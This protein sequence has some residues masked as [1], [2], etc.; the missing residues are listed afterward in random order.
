MDMDEKN[1]L[2]VSNAALQVAMG[3]KIRRFRKEKNKTSAQLALQ[4]G[5]TPSYITRLE[6]GKRSPS[7]EVLRRLSDVLETSPDELLG[8]KS[9]SDEPD[10][11]VGFLNSDAVKNFPYDVFGLKQQDFISLLTSD[12]EYGN[13]LSKTIRHVASLHHVQ[14]GPLLLEVLKFYQQAKNNYFEGIEKAAEAFRQQLGLK[15]G[16]P[17][18]EELLRSTLESR[19]VTIDTFKNQ[20]EFEECRW[21]YVN[22]DKESKLY[23]NE[24]LMPAQRAFC[25][26][27]EIGYM[28]LGEN[29]RRPFDTSELSNF[30]EAY[31]YFKAS[32]FAGS[33]MINKRS[34]DKF[35]LPFLKKKRFNSN[36]F[37]DLKMQTTFES[38]FYRIGELLATH[39]LS[40]YYFL[41]F[42]SDLERELYEGKKEIYSISKA[43]NM[44]SLPDLRGLD[45]REQYCGRFLEINLMRKL[46]EENSDRVICGV[47]RSKG[48]WGDTNYQGDVFVFSIA[49]KTSL[50]PSRLRAVSLSYPINERFK[51]LVGFYDAP[52]VPRK[53]VHVSC[54]RCHLADCK[55]RRSKGQHVYEKKNNMTAIIEF[56]NTKKDA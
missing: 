18:S 21:I 30:A 44:S 45:G 7:L 2:K 1:D 38:Y 23:I 39:G 5:V 31:A 16:D 56:I 14:I 51:E 41:R 13:V 20:D 29:P 28:E 53:E 36:V 33:A 48:L 50:N 40:K 4:I 54:E 15:P 34:F 52:D 19:G 17:L 22:S 24:S 3:L 8:N 12:P 55:Q 6:Q 46:R 25:F 27:R 37:L 11:I 26:A 42:E 32:Y 10:D 43:T 9:T 47:Q 49:Y 35:F